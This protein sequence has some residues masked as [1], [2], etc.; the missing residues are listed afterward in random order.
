MWT[1]EIAENHWKKRK[2]RKKIGDEVHYILETAIFF[3]SVRSPRFVFEV[4]CLA[5][6]VRQLLASECNNSIYNHSNIFQKPFD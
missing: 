3:S 4:V 2:K 6:F 5:F 1:R